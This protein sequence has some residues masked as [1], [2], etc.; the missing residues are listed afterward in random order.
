MALPLNKVQMAIR[1]ERRRDREDESRVSDLPFFRRGFA[2]FR[3]VQ[4]NGIEL[5]VAAVVLAETWA[6]FMTCPRCLAVMM[7]QRDGKR[8]IALGR[9]MC[10]VRRSL[11]EKRGREESTSHMAAARRGQRA[12]W[13]GGSAAVHGSASE[14]GSSRDWWCWAKAGRVKSWWYIA[15]ARNNNV[16]RLTPTTS[17]H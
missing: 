7:R 4:R 16:T 8:T 9:R 1:Q 6:I 15:T 3:R 13:S 11:E 5:L 17:A 12:L 14:R 10:T 2:C